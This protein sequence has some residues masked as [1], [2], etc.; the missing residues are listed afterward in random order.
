LE[1]ADP[2]C[3]SSVTAGPPRNINVLRALPNLGNRA[4]RARKLSSD[5]RWRYINLRRLFLFIKTPIDEGT[6]SVV[7][8]PTTSRSGPG[9]AV[10]HE[11]PADLWRTGA[12]EGTTPGEAFFVT[13]ERT[14]MM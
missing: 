6:Q 4:W 2:G 12:L 8:E 11:L 10:N 14:T 13:C 3:S 1:A 9:W 7:F 5:T